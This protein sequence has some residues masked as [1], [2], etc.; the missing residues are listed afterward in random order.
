[1]SRYDPRNLPG[2]E[3]L[4]GGGKP[5]RGRGEG[6]ERFTTG[7]VLVLSEGQGYTSP[8]GWAEAADIDAY[9]I[10][11][12]VTLEAWINY[13]T[14]A[15]QLT[16]VWAILNRYGDTTPTSGIGS[17]ST[18]SWQMLKNGNGSSINGL[19][20]TKGPS[21]TTEKFI[22]AAFPQAL[23]A[24]T[25]WHWAMSRNIAAGTGELYLNGEHY[26]S[27]SFTVAGEEAYNGP[28]Q[29]KMTIGRQHEGA[30]AW[31]LVGEVAEVRVWAGI[32]TDEEIAEN[33][34]QFLYGDEPG[35]RAYYRFAD[36]SDSSPNENPLIIR[37]SASL[38]QSGH[39]FAA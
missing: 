39:P 12:D 5:R 24:N 11:G 7:G 9:N 23:P 37:E 14:G 34:N 4:V 17:S 13:Y 33:Y 28:S 1:M 38:R 19:Y 8:N 25:W 30:N 20:W 16:S 21:T 29:R 3:S 2:V 35:L 26:A 15:P 36:T 22:G 6:R 10:P 31:R 18:R 27:G 32:R